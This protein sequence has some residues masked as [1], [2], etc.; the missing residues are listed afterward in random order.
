MERSDYRNLFVLKKGACTPSS[1]QPTSVSTTCPRHCD[2]EKLKRGQLFFQRNISNCVF[3]MLCSLVCG[4]SIPNLLDPLVFTKVS[5]TPK[6]SLYRYI[7]TLVH[8]IRWHLSDLWKADSPAKISIDQVRKMH[9]AVAE[10]MAKQQSDGKVYL[11]QYDMSLVQCGFVGA[12]VL[13][14]HSFAIQHTVNDLDDFVYLWGFIGSRLG[15]TDQN[16]ICLRDYHETFAICKQIEDSVL[17]PA[18]KNPPKDFDLMAKA[19]TNGLNRLHKVSLYTPEAV[20][21]FVLDIMGQS[22]KHQSITNE[23]RILIFKFLIRLKLY[24]PG[25]QFLINKLVMLFYTSVTRNE[26]KQR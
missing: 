10:A 17:L 15:I 6:K 19:F 7:Q 3:A 24:L 11:S 16:N 8:V 18:L 21:N 22:R 12:I 5:D 23:I 2:T 4:L 14:P 9:N 20:I 13:H 26:K 1:E 25:F